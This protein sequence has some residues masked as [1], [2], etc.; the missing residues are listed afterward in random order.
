MCYVNLCLILNKYI[1]S[2]INKSIK[3]LLFQYESLKKL[4]TRHDIHNA[5][6]VRLLKALVWQVVICGCESWTLIE[7]IGCRG[8]ESTVANCSGCGHPLT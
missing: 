8:Q 5:T 4:W 1:H 3:S 7:D 2:Y 6:K